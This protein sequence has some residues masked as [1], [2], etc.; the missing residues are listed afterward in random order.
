MHWDEA[1]HALTIGARRG[2]F[3]GMLRERAFRVVVVR[4]DHGVGVDATEKADRVVQYSGA[5]VVVKL[6]PS[7]S[8]YAGPKM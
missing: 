6:E 3:P 7:I 2:E 1:Q 8:Q 4:N 5:A